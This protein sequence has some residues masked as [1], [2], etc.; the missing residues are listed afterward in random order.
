MQPVV[1]ITLV[2]MGLTIPEAL[3][4]LSLEQALNVFRK[5]AATAAHG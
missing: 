5:D 4:A 1:A 3:T 2:Q